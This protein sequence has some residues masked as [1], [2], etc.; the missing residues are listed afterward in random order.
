MGNEPHHMIELHI[1]ILNSQD[2]AL[3]LPL[4]NRLGLKWEQRALPSAQNAQ[5]LE[6][7][8]RIIAQGGD[9]SYFG[10]AAA[11][12][13]EQREDRSLPFSES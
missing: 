5:K 1:K 4:L 8:Q 13:Q 2:L 7:L 9:A 11:W 12:Q 10:D 6:S 3:L